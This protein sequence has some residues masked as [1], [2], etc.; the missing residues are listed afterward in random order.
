MKNAIE[1]V[2]IELSNIKDLTGKDATSTTSQVL[3]LPLLCIK[4]MTQH[5]ANVEKRGK[6]WLNTQLKAA[7]S[8]YAVYTKTLKDHQALLGPGKERKPSRRRK[9]K[10]RHQSQGQES[11]AQTRA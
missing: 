11:E 2:K 9:T 10:V 4:F 8:K 6:T 1:H 5:L 7:E 3:S